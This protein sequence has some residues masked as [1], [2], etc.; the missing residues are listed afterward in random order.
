[1]QVFPGP[2]GLVRAIDVSSNGAT[3]RRPINRIAVLPIEDNEPP[4][5]SDVESTS[6]PGG[7][8]SVRNKL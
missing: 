5:L 3:Y 2:D 8:C 6:Q 7:V 4:T 1:M